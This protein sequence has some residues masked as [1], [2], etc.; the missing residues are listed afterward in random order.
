MRYMKKI[1]FVITH[2]EYGGAQ[3]FVYTLASNLKKD[4]YDVTVA[5]GKAAKN[6]NSVLDFLDTELGKLGIKTLKLNN[7]VRNPDFI[8]DIRAVFEIRKLIKSTKPDTLFL[9]SSKTGFNGSLASVF[10]SRIKGLRVI[11]RIGGW[12]FNDPWPKWKRKLWIV[13]ERISA[14]WKDIIIVNSQK[15]FD[16]GKRH[17]INSREGC[18]LVHNG[19]DPYE[20]K[21]LEKEDARLRLF[22]DIENSSRLFQSGIIVGTIANLYETKGLKYLV[23]VAK[24][25]RKEDVAFIVIGDGP[26]RKELTELIKKEGLKEK[27]FL[28]GQIADA[29]KYLKAFDIYLQPSVKEGFPWTVLEAM[30]AKLPVIA[31][32]VGAV[33]EMIEDGKS[34][35]I[36]APKK[37][38]QIAQA[39]LKLIEDD[40]ARREFGIQANQKVHFNFDLETMLKKIKALL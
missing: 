10:P 9:V 32:S 22:R 1:L 21:Y 3:R 28:T 24:Q 37:P 5:T 26:L 38:A 19:I 25:L 17:K 2:F 31:T 29:S 36:V 18:V 35:F 16:D 27:V 12:T 20:E 30:T 7:L 23:S 11:Y 33:P 14:S 15:D 4:E 13:L 6:D 39:I 40:H 8:K 34:G